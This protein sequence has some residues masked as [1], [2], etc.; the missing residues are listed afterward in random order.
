[1][2]SIVYEDI[3]GDLVKTSSIKLKEEYGQCGVN[4]DN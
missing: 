4:V 2:H 1:M 3:D